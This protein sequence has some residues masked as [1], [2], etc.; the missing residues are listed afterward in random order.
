MSSTLDHIADGIVTALDT[1]TGLRAFKDIPAAVNPPTAFP[2]L[3]QITYDDM[4]DSRTVNW[5]LLILVATAAQRTAQA[6]LRAYA[7]RNTTQSIRT[8]L[9]ADGTLSGTVMDLRVVGS[10]AP[11]IYTVAEIE[12][13]GVEIQFWTT[14]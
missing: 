4:E 3:G 7:D 13:Y 1:I 10:S 9:E 12:Y 14:D 8:A 6:S 5:S 11:Q 2:T